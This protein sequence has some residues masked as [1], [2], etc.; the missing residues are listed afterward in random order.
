MSAN[1]GDP[2]FKEI[3]EITSVIMR[4]PKERLA[5]FTCSFGAAESSALDLIGT[6]G[7]LRVEHA[8]EYATTTELHAFKNGKVTKKKFS[9]RDQFAPELEYFSECVIKNRQ[10]EP[11]G[12]E[13][14]ADIR[15][16]SA[17]LESAKTGRPVALEPFKKTVRPSSEQQISKRNNAQS[18]SVFHAKSA[19][20]E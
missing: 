20:G 7:R 4:F 19:T 15:I 6:E 11:S 13:G 12:H 1:S 14:L 10:P 2:R 18:P 8:Y 16:I 5:S 17:L 9:K 3:D